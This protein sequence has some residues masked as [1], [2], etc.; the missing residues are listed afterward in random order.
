MAVKLFK[1]PAYAEEEF[2][3][4][5]TYS[6]SLLVNYRQVTKRSCVNEQDLFKNPSK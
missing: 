2:S 3:P 5:H 6:L 1:F 4:L